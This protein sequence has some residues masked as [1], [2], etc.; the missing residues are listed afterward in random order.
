[1]TTTNIRL[2]QQESDYYCWRGRLPGYDA[3][4]ASAVAVT[5]RPAPAAFARGTGLAAVVGFL[6]AG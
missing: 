3:A 2:K 1:M 5:P 6:R 4:A